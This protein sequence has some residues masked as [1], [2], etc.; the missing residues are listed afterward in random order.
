MASGKSAL[1]VQWAQQVK[2]KMSTTHS[3]L[4]LPVSVKLGT[5]KPGILFGALAAC[6]ADIGAVRLPVPTA[7]PAEFYQDQASGLLRDLVPIDG[8]KC[9]LIID[10]LDEM[11]GL[12]FGPKTFPAQIAH[13]LRLVVSARPLAGDKGSSGWRSR[14]AWDQPQRPS[15]TL[16]L[17]QL[18]ESEI[19]QFVETLNPPVDRKIRTSVAAALARLARGDALMVR[20]LIQD[21]QAE[22]VSGRQPD[23]AALEAKAPGLAAFVREELTAHIAAAGVAEQET[24][25]KETDAALA[26]LIVSRYAMEETDLWEVLRR[27]LDEVPPRDRLLKGL[28][29]FVA[30]TSGGDLALAHQKLGQL[31]EEMLAHSTVLDRATEAFM[32][33]QLDTVREFVEHGSRNISPYVLSHH[34][35]HLASGLQAT[36][37]PQSKESW[38]R[39]VSRRWLSAKQAHSGS[40]GVAEDASAARRALRAAAE[41]GDPVALAVLL[42]VALVFA[43]QRSRGKALSPA[44][45]ALSSRF[46]LLP[47]DEV[48]LIVRSVS[49]V[50]APGVEH[51]WGNARTID[52][53]VDCSGCGNRAGE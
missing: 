5:S 48:E 33:W 42:R 39:V 37:S 18:Q 4:L 25:R 31:L 24:R 15:Q 9:V 21:L 53:L 12:T 16:E 50:R 47:S 38:S 8:R 19:R 17:S 7:D 29:R 41:D 3:V 35:D 36:A 14:L 43:T 11:D 49:I 20:W 26:V 40:T 10:G 23:V 30:R 1:L 6:L 44:L 52:R 22:L 46:G 13:H 51:G 28:S 2:I 27:M 34:A 45:L 32:A